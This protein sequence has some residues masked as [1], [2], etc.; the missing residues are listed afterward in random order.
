MLL[1]KHNTLDSNDLITIE[2]QYLR[3]S[4]H[5]GSFITSE[6]NVLDCSRTDLYGHLMG[7][8]EKLGILNTLNITVSQL[9]DF[10]VDIDSSYHSTPYHTFYHA[11]DIVTI[12]YFAV[13]ELEASTCFTNKEIAILFIAAVCHDVGHPGFNNDFQVKTR[14]DLAIRYN[15]TSVLES[16]SIDL[17]IPLIEKHGLFKGIDYVDLFR[18]LIL[19]TDM[20]YHY[21]LLQEA[22]DLE[23][24]PFFWF[25]DDKRRTN[26]AKILLHAA[27]I[28]NTVR[29]WPISK[30]WSDLIVQEFFQQG[31]A[32][33]SAGLTVSPGMD[34][35][36][37][38]QASISLRF[39]DLIVKPY[40]E[41]VYRLLPKAS[42]WIDTLEQNR[43]EWEK[44]KR[45]TPL[46][47]AI[48][49]HGSVS[50]P[51]GTVL[52]PSLL[53]TKMKPM[54]ILRASSHSNI[55]IPP[56]S[57]ISSELRRNSVQHIVS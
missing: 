14:S 22:R 4:K 55:L 46:T 2:R 52:L 43:I 33:R 29:V 40:F 23:E 38:S 6:F 49:R 44:V 7:I 50:I 36:L 27:D 20:A 47:A 8:F 37:A 54:R 5:K 21:D 26:F 1:L 17:S 9:L 48:R 13:T 34:R 32:E 16:H 10:L 11:A 15:N 42:V 24:D 35:A 12:L 18:K 25:W 39:G 51:A 19:S 57:S 56:Q 28:S 53:E 30:Q 45:E 41:A 31:D 3:W